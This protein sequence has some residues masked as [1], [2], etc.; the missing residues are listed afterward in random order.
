MKK[1]AR[2]LLAV[3][4]LMTMAT[5]GQAQFK[6]D[7]LQQK[8]K[9]GERSGDNRYGQ[10]SDH[11]AGFNAFTR[12]DHVGTGNNRIVSNESVLYANVVKRYG[13]WVG[14]GKPLTKEEASHRSYYYK[15]SKKNAAGHWT[16][17]QAL[18]GYG[19]PTT[20]HGI[21]LYM[22]SG[23]DFTSEDDDHWS[24]KLDNIC[25]WQM[26]ADNTGRNAIQEASYD[27]DGNL[28]CCFIRTRVSDT[29]ELGHYVDSWGEPLVFPKKRKL[30]SK[31]VYITTDER[32][33]EVRLDF[34]GEEGYAKRNRNDVFSELRFYDDR[35]C[36]VK[37]LSADATG[38]PVKDN[39]GNCGWT[40]TYTDRGDMLTETIVDEHE[41]PMRMP[42]KRTYNTYVFERYERDRWGRVLSETFFDE[43]GRPD[44]IEDGVHC[45]EY[46]YNEHGSRTVLRRLGLEGQLVNVAGVAAI[47]QDF[48][49]RGNYTRFELRDA[50]GKLV[51]N[52]EGL[53]LVLYDFDADF[54]TKEKRSYYTTNGTD[55]LLMERYVRDGN[56]RMWYT[57]KPSDDDV[58]DDFQPYIL[59]KELDGRGNQ[60]LYATFDMDM[61]PILTQ[62][63]YH[64]NVTTYDY[65]KRKT[66]YVDAY[67]GVDGDYARVGSTNY[68]KDYNRQEVDIDSVTNVRLVK[69]YNG[70][71][72]V[73]FYELVKDENGL[74]KQEISYD[75]FGQR[76]RSFMDSFFSYV[77][78]LGRTHR[79]K[80]SYITTLN[81]FGEPAYTVTGSWNSAPVYYV[82]VY[83]DPNYYDENGDTIPRTNM[84]AFKDSLQKAYCIEVVGTQA[85]K[86]G[87]RSG[88][89][90]V[91][92]G[93]WIYEH[94]RK[95]RRYYEDR[96]AVET[97]MDA[98]QP[99]DV[100]VLR[101][102][103]D[104]KQT[105]V[106]RLR[107]PKGTPME[108]G[109]I[110]HKLFLT[111]REAAQY[112]RAVADYIDEQGLKKYAFNSARYGDEDSDDTDV[113]LFFPYMVN[114]SKQNIPRLGMF[115]RAVTLGMEWWKDGESDLYV[116]GESTQKLGDII[117][118]ER[119]SLVLYYTTDGE[120]V[121]RLPMVLDTKR[122]DAQFDLSNVPDSLYQVLLEG[123]KAIRKV[124][125]RKAAHPL[126]F[127][128]RSYLP[129]EALSLLKTDLS[130]LKLYDHY[131]DQSGFTHYMKWVPLPAEGISRIQEINE[132]DDKATYKDRKLL[133]HVLRH[134][135]PG[136]G[137]EERTTE[138]GNRVYLKGKKD[139]YSEVVFV[140][141]NELL[142]VTG[143]MRLTQEDIEKFI[144][145]KDGE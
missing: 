10:K 111:K 83:G 29:Q 89:L 12:L 3:V 48:N 86:M 4:A 78:E 93:G 117:N 71:R 135:Q 73:N 38:T 127:D 108:L 119:D 141:K 90:I 11:I 94:T 35:G 130:A 100:V 134:I 66:H 55:T 68:E 40:A 44:T 136:K 34:I 118:Y 122:I 6:S 26:T 114:S 82:D 53:C 102:H 131:S 106:H 87:L 60:T 120:Q 74:N 124:Y 57:Y 96:L 113:V 109:F 76:A 107:L 22:M 101:R 20:S 105:T 142:V 32:G 24:K 70:D 7:F 54:N 28:V 115:E 145:E 41:Q 49:A 52:S 125:A 27:S 133:R 61:K 123:V 121:R 21:N 64:K 2:Y 84:T 92:Y 50:D 39:W 19:D 18:D 37:C 79:G 110:F 112:N 98:H 99:K 30:D 69:L 13:W 15:L 56:R 132:D 72:M 17:M 45:R 81:E 23:G 58:L 88:D 138:K 25:Q 97:M 8:M 91:Q 31:Y 42:G 126:E 14:I 129:L 36:Y 137:Y 1:M 9:G 59:V 67:Y 104:T 75:R 46:K 65:G 63:G 85:L 33:Y 116:M 143:Q 128:E 77:R 62:F 5:N 144:A 16:Y 139:V 43:L 103:P 51:N 140:K 95:S 80:V 47:Y